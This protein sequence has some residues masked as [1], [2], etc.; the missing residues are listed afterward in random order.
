[1]WLKGFTGVRTHSAAIRR[2]L[3]KELHMKERLCV[4]E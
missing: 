1:V 3:Q 2:V 4:R